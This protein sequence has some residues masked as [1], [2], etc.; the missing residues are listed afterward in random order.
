MFN[1]E[2]V[3]KLRP[4]MKRDS[5]RAVQLYFKVTPLYL[6]NIFSFHRFNLVYTHVR[7]LS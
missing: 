1:G 7:Y 4:K 2:A 5:V 3:T 6:I